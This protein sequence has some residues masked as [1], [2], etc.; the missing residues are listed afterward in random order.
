MHRLVPHLILEE[1]AAGRR[2]GEIAA[3]G[4]FADMSGFSA[5]TD[6]LMTHGQ[7]GA[8]VLAVVLRKAF[9]PMI[10]SVYEQGGFV[11]TQ[12]GDAFTA[13]F[14]V[15]SNPQQAAR[16]ALTAA[17]AIQEHI[18]AQAR[19]QTPYGEFSIA[20]KIG[21]ASGHAAWG[22]LESRDG[23]Q[24]VCYFKGSAIDESARA[25]H[26]AGRGQ[27]ILTSSFQQ[28]V[29]DAVRVEAIEDHFRLLE[30]HGARVPPEPVTLPPFD[31]SLATRFFPLELLTQ[32]FAGEFRQVVGL[33]AGMPQIQQ[34]MGLEKVMQTVFDLQKKYGGLVKLYFGDKGPHILVI[35]GAPLAYENDV[36]RALSFILDLRARVETPLHA[37]ITY[38]IAHAGCIGSALSEEYATFGRGVNLAAR[39]MTSAP[40]GEIWVDE[41]VARRARASFDFAYVEARP[42]KGFSQPQKV[43]TLLG[44]KPAREIEYTSPLAGRQTELSR[45]HAF[46]QP[47]FEGQPAGLMVVF[48][49]AGMGKS[50]LVYEFLSQISRERAA[51]FLAQTDQLLRESLNPFRYWLRH[52]F[53]I[54][55]QASEERNK[56]SFTTKLDDLIAS[57][58]AGELTERLKR[59]HSF[60][61]ALVGLRWADSPYEQLDAEARY[62]NTLLGL[63][64]LLQAESLRQPV[65]LFL[66]DIHWLDEDS[67]AYLPR[68]LRALTA[69]ETAHYPIALLA[70]SR[71][72]DGKLAVETL[73]HAEL[74]L[75]RLDHEALRSMAQAL[76]NGPISA[77]LLHVVE[78]RAE[79]NP[80][81]AEQILRYAQEEGLLRFH[82]GE[83][84]F[85][86]TTD[87]P[88]LPL[89]VNALLIARLD[90]LVQEVRETVQNAAILGREF[91]VQVLA[92]L[93][94]RQDLSP[95]GLPSALANAERE[96]IW[97]ALSEIRYI[98]RHALMW[99]AAYH[100]Q[101]HARRQT[102][103]AAAVEALESLYAEDLSNHY[104]ELAYHAERAHLD[105]KARTYLRQAA[106]IAKGAYQNSQA[107]DYYTRALAL[108]PADDLV[109]QYDLLMA[110]LEVYQTQGRYEDCLRDLQTL[111]DLAARIGQPERML[112]ILLRKTE[113]IYDKGDSPQSLALGLQALALA[114][115]IK[116]REKPIFIYNIL[117]NAAQ[118]LGGYEQAQEFMEKGLTL[119]RTFGDL[120]MESKLLNTVGMFHAEQNDLIQ[121]ADYFRQSLELARQAN[122]LRLQARP[123]ANLGMAAIRHG[124]FLEAR[125]YTEESLA[126]AR[127]IGAR[128]GEALILGNLGFIEG[129]L[130]N[131]E[132][133]AEYAE[134]GL[135][136]ARE[137][138]SKYHEVFALI[139]L[140]SYL[141]ALGRTETALRAARDGLKIA[142]QIGEQ[143]G[144]AW[145][146]TYLGHNL[147]KA[148]NLEEARQA[149]EHALQIRRELGQVVLSAEPLAGLAELAF[150]QGERA[151]AQQITEE[152]LS[153]LEQ[154]SHLEGSDD[155]LRVYAICLRILSEA[156]DTRAETLSNTAY[157][158]LQARSTQIPEDT[159]R[160]AFL[161]NDINQTILRAWRRQKRQ[162]DLTG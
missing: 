99:N 34:E 75:E 85:T 73:P 147:R 68:L 161:A 130:G 16:R 43:F 56:R 138:G 63:T 156:H 50:R 144:A 69:D 155:P 61:G 31:L 64:A 25:E 110:R 101:L 46:V 19:P 126:L 24:A 135:R 141:G 13:L 134:A 70:T 52:Y 160:Q 103:H 149:Y 137:I 89:D 2:R 26:Y 29:R 86:Q 132:R 4:M 100:M 20:V 9:A 38:R 118:R 146:F 65:I 30:Y 72:E 41:F 105:Q 81:F 159:R 74:Q 54:T 67:A 136:I 108:T 98:F 133:A 123:L 80:F 119:A 15:H 49:E 11:A 82:S 158:L 62:Q 53:G 45:L 125:R 76:L 88:T 22:I 127:Q 113:V 35:W 129:S 131:Y 162:D 148:G 111:N 5:M 92:R 152:I 18:Q 112:E 145:A 59:A 91:E 33:F 21:L 90:R 151:R 142:Q 66:E 117:S 17:L 3:V 116:N 1:Y 78:T 12:A 124:D 71:Y 114:E 104:G 23:M 97:A 128:I 120:R 48:G 55:A 154:N 40:E 58:P 32:R 153:I 140:S 93:L 79:G 39:F 102:L 143:S 60:L 6:E 150:A 77:T 37:G 95:A 115:S 57:L 107:A 106:E 83:W 94:E 7:H 28:I 109:G 42:F 27:V 44:R 87:T 14:P 122:D 139:N 10:Q 157:E 84:T 96:A 47:I 121:A 51:W 8:E 36:E